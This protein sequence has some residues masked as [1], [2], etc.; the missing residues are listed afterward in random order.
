MRFTRWI[1]PTEMLIYVDG[2]CI[3]QGGTEA[4]AYRRAGCAFVFGPT[5][6]Y[7]QGSHVLRLEMRGSDHQEHAVTSNRAELHA[8]I[9]ALRY[10]RWD[11]E[12]WRKITIASNSSYLVDG[13]TRHIE[14]WQGNGWR[15]SRGQPVANKDF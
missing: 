3:G 2:S 11:S 12:G 13:I 6:W 10:H 9:A 14:T 15:N 4:D 5:S 1:D 7:G 8:A